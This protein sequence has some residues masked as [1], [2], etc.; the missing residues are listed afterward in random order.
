VEVGRYQDAYDSAGS[1]ISLRKGN[2]DDPYFMCALAKA[3][4]G[5]GRFQDAQTALRLIAAKKP[6]VKQSPEFLSA[7]SF[8]IGKIRASDEKHPPESK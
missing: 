7:V 6:E 4:A 1:A 3:D 5:L 2:M 8:V